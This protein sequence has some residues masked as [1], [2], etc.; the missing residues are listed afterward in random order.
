M[1]RGSSFWQPAEKD[2]AVS[3]EASEHARLAVDSMAMAG[4]KWR[5]MKKGAYDTKLKQGQLADER[6]KR[7]PRCCLFR[8]AFAK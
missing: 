1:H 5:R 7:K 6:I 2:E 3:S 8:D 4:K